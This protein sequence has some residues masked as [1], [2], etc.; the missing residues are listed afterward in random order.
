MTF[1][2]IQTAFI[3]DVILA[4]PLIEKIHRFYPGAQ[5]DMLVRKGNESL[6]Q[7]HPLL[8]KCLIW[9]KKEGKYRALWQILQEI[10]ATRYDYVINCQRFAA[11]GFLTVRSGAR[12]TIGFDKNPLSFWFKHRIPHQISASNEITHEVSRN[13][14]LIER[15]TDASFEK[16]A[17]YP[18]AKEL[19][20]A[21]A[22][23]G[24]LPYVCIAPTSVWFTKQWPAH[25]WVKLIQQLPDHHTVFLLGAPADVDAC[26]H[27]LEQAKRPTVRTVAGQLSLLASAALMKNAQ[28]NYVNDSAPMHLASAVNAPVTAIFCST[29]PAFGFTPLS[30]HSRVIETSEVLPCRPCGLHGYAKCPKGHFKCAETI[31]INV[32]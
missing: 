18:S 27:I 13:L 29:I 31:E 22:L 14:A 19:A 11:S 23:A 20:Q 30:D 28:M 15:L 3:G 26:Q 12:T 16:P 21:A 6:L 8:R 2:L 7:E 5:I 17:L 24:P 10:R 32:H 1:L 25:K 4:T 9:N